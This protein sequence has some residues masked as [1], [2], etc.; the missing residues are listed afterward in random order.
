[1]LKFPN[2]FICRASKVR[3]KYN[4]VQGKKTKQ[5]MAGLAGFEPVPHVV[6]VVVVARFT[7]GTKRW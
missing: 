3:S 1:L 4:T 2:F 6:V 5:K 7:K